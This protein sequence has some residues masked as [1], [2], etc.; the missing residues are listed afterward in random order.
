[1]K[2]ALIKLT[3]TPLGCIASD[4]GLHPLNCEPTRPMNTLK[5]SSCVACVYW[6]LSVLFSLCL[7]IS[8][9]SLIFAQ[10]CTCN[11]KVNMTGEYKTPRTHTKQI[12]QGKQGRQYP[13]YEKDRDRRLVNRSYFQATIVTC[14]S[15]SSM[16]SHDHVECN[17]ALQSQIDHLCLFSTARP[18]TIL[19][20]LIY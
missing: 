18:V 17:K 9:C 15:D 8:A 1:M 19:A 4:G 2:E 5:P 16:K 12:E 6:T 14:K 3:G 7:S 20:C 13:S 10:S 11:Y